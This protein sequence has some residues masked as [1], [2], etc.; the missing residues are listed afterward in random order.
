MHATLRI[1]DSMVELGDSA[2]P[3]PMNLH[4][5]I[6]NVD[7]LYQRAVAA[8]GISVRPPETTFYGDRGAAVES[9]LHGGSRRRDLRTLTLNWGQ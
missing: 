8:G 7:S 6:D 2:E 3:M 4:L 9:S 1:G 5:Y